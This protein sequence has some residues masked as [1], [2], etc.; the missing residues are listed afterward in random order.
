MDLE[1][2]SSIYEG[3]VRHRRYAPVQNRFRYHVFF[4]YLDLEEL[5]HLFDER[6]LWSVDHANIANCKRS[7]YLGPANVPL[8]RAVRDKVENVLGAGQARAGSAKASR[9]CATP[10]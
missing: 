3:W 7:D 1:E 4:M 6:W 9:R 8:D 10:P 2:H 5:P